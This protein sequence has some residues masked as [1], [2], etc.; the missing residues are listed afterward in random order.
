[1]NEP[2]TAMVWNENTQTLAQLVCDATWC[3]DEAIRASARKS[4]VEKARE[5]PE[6]VTDFM[7]FYIKAQ[8]TNV[9]PEQKRGLWLLY[10]EVRMAVA[11]EMAG[12]NTKQMHAMA[13]DA[14]AGIPLKRQA[15]R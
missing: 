6:K 15:V 11:R 5:D 9:E 7:Q 8:A 13:R 3:K 1:M 2:N 12:Q 10:G 4:L 14:S